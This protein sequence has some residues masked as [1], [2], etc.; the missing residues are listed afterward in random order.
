MEKIETIIIGGGQAGLST[1]YHLKQ[2]GREHV[3]FEAADKPAHAWR[4]DRWDSFTLVTPNWTI[5]LPGA[6]YDG[7]DPDGYLP[8]EEI[9]AYF[10]HYIEKYDLP[11]RFKTSVLEVAQLENGSGYQVKTSGGI[12]QAKN[13][14]I[15]TGSFQKPKIP[16]YSANIPAEILQLH[17]G[18]YRNPNQLPNGAVLVVGSGQSGMQIAEELYQSGRKIYLSTGFAPRAPRWYRNRDVFAW[19]V[20]TGFFEQTPDKLP[21]LKAR[22]GANPQLSGKDGGHSLNLHQFARDGVALLGHIADAHSGK[23]KFKP[24]LKENL[25]RTDKAEKDI[26]AMIDKYIEANKFDAPQETLSELQDGYS[27]EIIT[28][29]DLKSANINTIIWAMGYAFDYNLVKLP[30]TDEDGFPVTQRGVTQYTGLYFV[31]MNWLSKRK[32]TL[33][34]GVNEDVEHIIAEITR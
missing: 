18:H 23:V 33:L 7:N 19:L 31:G 14:V 15:A 34:L 30:V 3:V 26:C 20:D 24:D 32:S 5:Q 12:F 8:K 28:E 10:E 6:R 21:T 17:S 13:V 11:V 25:A 4:D 29:L 1:S 27:A 16:A 9:V 2:L 22:F